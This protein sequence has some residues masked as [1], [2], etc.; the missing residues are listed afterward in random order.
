MS[1]N[2]LLDEKCGEK[3]TLSKELDDLIYVIHEQDMLGLLD[4]CNAHIE[5]YVVVK[6]AKTLLKTVRFL[7]CCNK[8]GSNFNV[9][10]EETNYP[11]VFTSKEA[12]EKMKELETS[13][14]G[15]EKMWLSNYL[16]E[17]LGNI[18]TKLKN[19]NRI[20]GSIVS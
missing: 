18:E 2:E 4:E 1:Y 16:F 12:D 9:V 15:L 17:R 8:V 5:Q 6:K 14:N 20:I 7:S 13:Y 11:E 10:F 19:L 3:I